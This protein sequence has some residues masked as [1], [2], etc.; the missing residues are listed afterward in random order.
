MKA[1]VSTRSDKSTQESKH[2]RN[3]YNC[4]THTIKM[5]DKDYEDVPLHRAKYDEAFDFDCSV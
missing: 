2:I 1:I 4:L 5:T 3:H